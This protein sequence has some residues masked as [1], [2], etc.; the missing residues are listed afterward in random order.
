MNDGRRDT[1]AAPSLITGAADEPGHDHTVLTDA[2]CARIA[3]V[4]NASVGTRGLTVGDG[5]DRIGAMVPELVR[6]GLAEL[7]N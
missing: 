1:A 2:D 3:T 5:F 7:R 6:R 4:L